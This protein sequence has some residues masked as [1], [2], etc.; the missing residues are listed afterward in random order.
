[1]FVLS[2]KNKQNHQKSDWRINESQNIL[3]K[4]TTTSQ[5]FYQQ[6]S[7]ASTLALQIHSR[8]QIRARCLKEK[9]KKKKKISNNPWI[10]KYLEALDKA[11]MLAAKN[12][13]K[14][15]KGK[16]IIL[17]NVDESMKKPCKTAQGFGK[18]MEFKGFIFLNE[19]LE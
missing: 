16:T 5:R 3:W 15:I 1:M 12:N 17:C 13:I 7:R 8:R 2:H 10:P 9:K 18:P 6:R 4:S 19:L 14:P 11:I